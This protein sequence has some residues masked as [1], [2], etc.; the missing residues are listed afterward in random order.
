MGRMMVEDGELRGGSSR[1]SRSRWIRRRHR[2]D[3]VESGGRLVGQ[4]ARVW[5][6]SHGNVVSQQAMTGDDWW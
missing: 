3:L 2:R 6:V 1:S 4:S 5:F